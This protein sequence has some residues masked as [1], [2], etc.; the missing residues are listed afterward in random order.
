MIVNG[1]KLCTEDSWKT[2]FNVPMQMNHWTELT[3][4]CYGADI[5]EPMPATT[6]EECKRGCEEYDGCMFITFG[7]TDNYPRCIY[8]NGLTSVNSCDGCDDDGT[9]GMSASCDPR[10]QYCSTNVL[11]HDS[12]LVSN[13]FYD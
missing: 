3:E 11:T 5:Y 8:K 4:E 2:P 13:R 12:N 6:L 7:N 10:T 1:Q 9:C